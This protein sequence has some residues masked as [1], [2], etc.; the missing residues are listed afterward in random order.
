MLDYTENPGSLGSELY[1]G[2]C[3]TLKTI[4]SPGAISGA[5]VS[6]GRG[7]A[8]VHNDFFVTVSLHCYLFAG[9]VRHINIR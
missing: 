4:S 1:C 9:F 5:S 6:T 7:L 3:G 8:F 2:Y